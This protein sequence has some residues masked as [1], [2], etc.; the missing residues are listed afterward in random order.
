MS[1][2]SS[3]AGCARWTSGSGK[4]L[5]RQEAE[6]RFPSEWTAWVVGQDVR[7]G[8]GET[9]GEAGARVAAAIEEALS[10]QASSNGARLVVVGHGLSLRAG[11]EQLRTDRVIRLRRPRSPPRQRRL[12]RGLDPGAPT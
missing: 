5:T 8:G 7:R 6:R 3:I 2:F 1:P 12:V 10:S 11:L 9:E 4:G